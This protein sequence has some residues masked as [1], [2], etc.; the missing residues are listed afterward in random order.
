MNIKKLIDLLLSGSGETDTT[1]AQA[2]GKELKHYRVYK[3]T[4]KDMKLSDLL[5]LCKKLN[6]NIVINGN[7]INID[8]LNFM[9][10]N[11]GQ[12]DKNKA[13]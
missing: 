4:A 11:Q 6:Y 10:E 2:L 13:E 7:N 5:K 3:S 1:A 12:P 8:L 9:D